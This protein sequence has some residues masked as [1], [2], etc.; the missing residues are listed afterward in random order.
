MDIRCGMMLRYVSNQNWTIWLV[1]LQKHGQLIRANTHTQSQNIQ[2][3]F[4]WIFFL[5]KAS[6]GWH[7]E[8]LMD[9]DLYQLI[10]SHWPSD[11]GPRLW[12]LGHWFNS[13]EHT[14]SGRSMIQ[15]RA[16]D[17][18]KYLAG[19]QACEFSLDPKVV[20]LFGREIGQSNGD[21]LLTGVKPARIKVG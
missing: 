13:W 20:T 19:I 4:L 10:L 7:T 6:Q 8:H 16:M 9:I 12:V 3:I 17:P 18:S 21:I 5:A 15:A 11:L 2:E 1:R 14:C